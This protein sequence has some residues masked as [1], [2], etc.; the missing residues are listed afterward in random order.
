MVITDSD[1]NMYE[2]L[3]EH[4]YQGGLWQGTHH[5]LCQWHLLNCGWNK[6]VKPHVPNKDDRLKDIG[7][8]NRSSYLLSS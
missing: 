2:A 3:R 5:F 1:S 8:K 4:T 7:K 6:E